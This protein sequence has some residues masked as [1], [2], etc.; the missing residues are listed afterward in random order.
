VLRQGL[1]DGS[2]AAGDV[3]EL[4]DLGRVH[5]DGVLD[6]GLGQSEPGEVGAVCV[7]RVV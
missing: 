6:D 1:C 3:L 7:A 2:D 4:H 5:L